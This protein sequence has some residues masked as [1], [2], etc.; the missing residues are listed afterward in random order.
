MDNFETLQGIVNQV[1]YASSAGD[2]CVFSV[3][4]EGDGGV[5]AEMVATAASDVVEGEEVKLYGSHVTHP[6]Y[7]NQFKAVMV[8]K[9]L[10][11]TLTGMEKYLSSG[12]IK[13][14]GAK[15]ARLIV[16]EFGLSTFDV[17]E[18]NP[19]LM[20]K[21]KGITPA[22][23]AVM[24]RD[25]A[26]TSGQRNTMMH[27]QSLGLTAN[28]CK[29]IYE[30]YGAESISRIKENPYILIRDI[31]GVGFRIADSIA[32]RSGIAF[33]SPYRLSA[34]VIH[35]LLEVAAGDGHVF[36]PKG[37]L[38]E[39]SAQL[40]QLPEGDIENHLIHMQVENELKL[41]KIE[42]TPAIY[43]AAHFH[44]EV[45]TARK[46][47]ELNSDSQLSRLNIPKEIEQAEKETGIKL[48][49]MQKVAVEE[50]L[51][52]G[53]VVIT[54]GPGTGK[55]TTIKTIISILN[56][57]EQ[58]IVLCAPTGRAAKRMNE[59]TG[60]PS[61]TI[62]RLLG[63]FFGGEGMAPRDNVDDDMKLEA[64]CI[65]VDE[66]SMVDIM[67]IYRLLKYVRR[68]TRLVLVG[69]VNQLPSVGPGNVL[70][71]I[72]ASNEIRSVYLDEIFR[73]GR[74]SAIVMNAHR[75]NQGAYP[76]I[77]DKQSDFFFIREFNIGN[78]VE[79]IASLAAHRLP[80]FMNVKPTEIQILCPQR[81][82]AC[83]VENL[84][85]TLQAVLNPPHPSKTERQMGFFT[86]RVGDKVM[87][88]KNNYQL[89]WQV[90]DQRGAVI[91]EGMGIFNGDEGRVT[92]IDTANNTLRVV[93]YDDKVVDYDFKQLD[94]LVLAYAITIHK[95]QGSEYDVVILP[96]HSGTPLLFNRNL[97]YTAITRAK[98]LVV[99]V[100]IEATI[101]RMVDNNRENV[102][103]SA[104]S[105]RLVK[106]HG[107]FNQKE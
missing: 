80:K 76:I 33:D 30:K 54:G 38:V 72:I 74:E 49:A 16:E 65:I 12:V 18:N 59:A 77:N 9:V 42:D 60:M 84:N 63:L 62:H 13:G 1:I 41:E 66:A 96:I 50:C 20:S 67:L 40:L 85:K 3:G 57:L 15:R 98:K 68:G 94:E 2:F 7:G 29:K 8:E 100:G 102:R 101:H 48:A 105:N 27:L 47:M 46:L 44:A 36:L 55:T 32:I 19:A 52:N 88:I 87:H 39:R 51:K 34:G 53:V 95:S 91:D 35:V 61:A 22:M 70:K 90:F 6:N 56:K 107:I 58:K 24:G 79:T 89:V 81:K 5:K 31:H 14:I 106:F 17:L 69:D 21:I 37:E 97:L 10:P 73:Q 71:D 82:T 75:I 78:A 28:Q 104:L 43:L 99:I 11:R 4:F 64:D 45:Y 23:A 26:E 103:H 83:G 93:F 92:H 25:F 86:F